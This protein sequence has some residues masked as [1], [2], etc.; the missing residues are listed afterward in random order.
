MAKKGK[1]RDDVTGKEGPLGGHVGKKTP[2]KGKNRKRCSDPLCKNGLVPIPLMP[3]LR[4]CRS[5]HG[6]G[7]IDF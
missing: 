4:Q 1:H 7:W 3:G 2:A 6:N 5:C